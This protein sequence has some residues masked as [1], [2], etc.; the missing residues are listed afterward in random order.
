MAE[1]PLARPGRTDVGKADDLEVTQKV[2][3][4]WSAIEV[5]DERHPEFKVS[6][7]IVGSRQTVEVEAS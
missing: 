4:D 1:R 3:S 2:R 7:N 6:Q 5:L